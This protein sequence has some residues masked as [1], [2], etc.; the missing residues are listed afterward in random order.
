[1]TD[2]CNAFM[3]SKIRDCMDDFD[4][5]YSNMSGAQLYEMFLMQEDYKPTLTTDNYSRPMCDLCGWVGEVYAYLHYFTSLR[6]AKL[7]VELPLITLCNYY[8]DYGSSYVADFAELLISQSTLDIFGSSIYNKCKQFVADC[9]GKIVVFDINGTLAKYQ[10]SG[11]S[12]HHLLPC[13]SEHL[14]VFVDVSRKDIYKDVVPIAPIQFII[15][16]LDKHNVYIMD[17]ES[18]EF[19]QHYK[20]NWLMINFPNLLS[21]NIVFGDNRNKWLQE[22]RTSKK[23]YDIVCVS[24]DASALI[25]INDTIEDIMAVHTSWLTV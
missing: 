23:G 19:I 20:Q 8:P 21:R 5:V 18:N 24:S 25:S 22:L 13:C 14:E 2:F 10:L 17:I 1:M 16:N 11:A 15:A 12:K 4:V 9:K 3:K 7:I 6:S